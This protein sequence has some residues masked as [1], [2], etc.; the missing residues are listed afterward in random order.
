LHH[1]NDPA[2]HGRSVTTYLPKESPVTRVDSEVKSSRERPDE[3]IDELSP[4]AITGA[5]RRK[6]RRFLPALL[7]NSTVVD[8]SKLVQ[9]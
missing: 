8:N 3:A 6:P 1:R 4:F 5:P 2:R 9:T 7:E